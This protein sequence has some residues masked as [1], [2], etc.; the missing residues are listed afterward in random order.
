MLPFLLRPPVAAAPG[1]RLR[2]RSGDDLVLTACNTS[3]TPETD[4]VAKHVGDALRVERLDAEL[5]GQGGHHVSDADGRTDVEE[6]SE[7]RSADVDR[8]VR[9]A[10]VTEPARPL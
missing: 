9:M 2:Q 7:H 10:H 5:A 6:V 8:A 3:H 1:H 4:L